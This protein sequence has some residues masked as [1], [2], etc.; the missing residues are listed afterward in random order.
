MSTARIDVLIW[1]L[2]Y[3]GLLAVGLGLQVQ[4]SDSGLGLSVIVVGAIVAAIGVLLV[5]VRSRMKDNP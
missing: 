1:V 3:G 2:I 5:Y 4:R